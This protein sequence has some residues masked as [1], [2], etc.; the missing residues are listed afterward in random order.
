MVFHNLRSYDSHLLM[1]AISK[2]KGTITC[3]Q[4]NMEK[5]ISFF[6][7]CDVTKKVTQEGDS[8]R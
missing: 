8:R 7:K 1:Q 2:V 3:I 4:N 6:L 5:Y